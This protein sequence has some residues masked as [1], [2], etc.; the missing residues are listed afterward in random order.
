MSVARDVLELK[1]LQLSLPRAP[2][3]RPFISST[4]RCSYGPPSG[5]PVSRFAAAPSLTPSKWK[6]RDDSRSNIDSDILPYL[7]AVPIQLLPLLETP[8]STPQSP[9]PS[10]SPT[11]TPSGSQSQSASDTPTPTDLDT[12]H[13]ISAQFMPSAAASASAF[14]TQSSTPLDVSASSGSASSSQASSESTPI[15]T[16]AIIID[17]SS[18]V[19]VDP[20]FASPQPVRDITLKSSPRRTPNF[21]FVPLLPVQDEHKP[22]PEPPVQKP[23]EPRR[24]FN[25]AFVLLL[26]PVEVPSVQAESAIPA[27]PQ[28][29]PS[30]SAPE[31]ASRETNT[32]PPVEEALASFSLHHDIPSESEAEDATDSESPP[33]PSS[34][35][36]HHRRRL[37]TI[38]LYSS[39]PSSSTTPSLSSASDTDDMD[40]E[41]EAPSVVDGESVPGSPSEQGASSE[42]FAVGVGI[43]EGEV[44]PYF[45]MLPSSHSTSS[46]QHSP[47]TPRQRPIP[48][49]C[50]IARPGQTPPLSSLYPDVTVPMLTKRGELGEVVVRKVKLE[51]IPSPSLVPP[52]PFSLYPPSPEFRKTNASTSSTQQG[53]EGPVVMTKRAFFTR[54]SSKLS[55]TSVPTV[56]F[57]LDAEEEEE[58]Q[59]IEGRSGLGLLRPSFRRRKESLEGDH[60]GED[61]RIGEREVE[62]MSDVSMLS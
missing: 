11:P 39:S 7:D 9:S 14:T 30:P 12:T 36:Q 4:P 21:Q 45:P 47:H 16:P 46:R 37:M 31:L 19:V 33:E 5:P 20:P 55:L 52:S 25:M 24:K 42:Y 44:N 43:T 13:S 10:P 48:D 3:H 49:L 26:P 51:A 57:A 28:S 27:A 22:P 2:V 38:P 61:E 54:N 62:M 35:H 34:H 18:P 40:T 58:E 8:P 17:P 1:Q 41:S 50:M 15:V 6:N 53:A 56:G 29:Q 60:A 59:R 32:A 23:V